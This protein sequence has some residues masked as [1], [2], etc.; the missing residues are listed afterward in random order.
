MSLLAVK[1]LRKSFDG[2]AAVADV[3]FELEAGEIAALIGP[4]G[5]GK[6][7]LFNMLSGQLRPDAGRVGFDGNDITG[8]PPGRIARLGIGRTFQTS[9]IFASMT[10]R[11]NIQVAAIAGHR[12]ALGMDRPAARLFEAEADALLHQVGLAGVADTGAG[13]LAYGDAKRLD[14]ALALVNRPVL[15]LMDEPTA[16]MGPSERAALMALVRDTARAR[17]TAILFTEHDMAAVFAT[18]DRV[19]VLDRGALIADGSPDAVRAD[20]QVRAVYLGEDV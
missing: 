11:E 6:S 9:G 8:L 4:N 19:L 18:A 14:L 3:S 1:N 20:A 10:V 5:A 13:A 17:S 2:L 15:L 7:T 12:Q 16:G